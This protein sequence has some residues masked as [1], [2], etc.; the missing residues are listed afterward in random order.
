MKQTTVDALN[1]RGMLPSLRPSTGGV[2]PLRPGVPLEQ[3]QPSAFDHA[4][5]R[6]LQPPPDPDEPVEE[7]GDGADEFHI[8]RHA[9]GRLSSRGIELTKQDV[10]ELSLALDA[11]ARRNAKESLV[12]FGENAF[13]FGVPK[14]TLITAM[15]RREAM[16]T[17]FTNIDSAMVLR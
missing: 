10:E 8:S 1:Y 11:L 2:Q 5:E 14:R 17:V 3:G 6:V 4:L 7:A 9:A 12:L 15:T 16:G 13:V